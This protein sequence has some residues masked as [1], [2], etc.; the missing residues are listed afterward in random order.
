MVVSCPLSS[1]HEVPESMTPLA[2]NSF[3]VS[4]GRKGSVNFTC[5]SHIGNASE[6]AMS[7]AIQYVSAASCAYKLASQ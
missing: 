6:C 4:K 7:L 5:R 2:V 1:A 3:E